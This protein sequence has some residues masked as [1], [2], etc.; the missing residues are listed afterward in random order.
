MF[1]NIIYINITFLLT[2]VSYFFAQNFGIKYFS[3]F[4]LLFSLFS[5]ACSVVLICSYL[6]YRNSKESEV[7]GLFFIGLLVYGVGNLFWFLNTEFLNSFV[8]E[9][10]LDLIFCFQ[11]ITK[12]YLFKYL[13]EENLSIYWNSKFLD[14]YILIVLVLMFLGQPQ[15]PEIFEYFFILDSI[16]SVVVALKLNKAGILL[17]DFNFLALASVLWFLADA[18]Y[19]LMSESGKYLMGN[20]VDFIYFIGFYLIISSI[21]YKNFK[22]SDILNNL[23]EN[24]GYYLYN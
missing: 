10:F 22:F 20:I 12:V 15:I 5:I 19:L 13:I 18:F 9:K 1:K 3:N 16:I 23:F 11:T 4:Y 8:P 6:N 21:V 7:Y 17:I 24:R 14:F 2:L